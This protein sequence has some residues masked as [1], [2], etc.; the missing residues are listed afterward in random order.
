MRIGDNPAILA[1]DLASSDIL[2]LTHAPSGS[3]TNDNKDKKLSLNELLVWLVKRASISF[4]AYTGGSRTLENLVSTIPITSDTI[5]LND[6]TTPGRYALVAAEGRTYQNYPNNAVNGWLDVYKYGG[7]IKQYFHRI[8]SFPTTFKDEFFRMY[9]SQQWSDWIR[10]IDQTRLDDAIA[11]VTASS[12]GLANS[13]VNCSC[14]G[15]TVV[16]VTNTVLGNTGTLP[17]GTYI[18]LAGGCWD[19]I[20][21]QKNYSIH[22]TNKSDGSGAISQAHV[23]NGPANGGTFMQLAHL[24][25]ITSNTTFYFACWQNSGTDV[26]FSSPYLKYVKLHN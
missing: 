13:V 24:V 5:N 15:K 8:G 9:A 16:S 3:G 20:S 10:I 23:T 2:L 21:V 6:I 22:L 1:T 19:S 7:T 14:A 25:S 12:L 26:V 18:I 11:G 4:N 17:P